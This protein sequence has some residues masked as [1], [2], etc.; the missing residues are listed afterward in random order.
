MWTPSNHFQQP[1]KHTHCM[2]ENS[3]PTNNNIP[4]S[5]TDQYPIHNTQALVSLLL[6]LISFLQSTQT[7]SH[8]N[9]ML[10]ND[11][12]P[13]QTGQHN[14][15][16]PIASAFFGLDNAIGI[17]NNDGLVISFNEPINSNSL[18]ASD[19]VIVDTNGNAH[20]PNIAT[21]APANDAGENQSVLLIGQ[22][23]NNAQAAPQQIHIVDDLTTQNQFNSTNLKGQ[24]STIIPLSAGP[25]LFSAQIVDPRLSEFE[26]TQNGQTLQVAWQG[27]ITPAS[28]IIAEEELNQFYTVY[29][30][31]NTGQ[32][33]AHTPS[34]IADINDNDNYHQ[35]YVNTTDP[36]VKVVVE[37]NSV[38]DPNNDPNPYTEIVL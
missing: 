7:S 10:S 23:G 20:T 19:F 24:S 25:E 3:T 33:I 4:Y 9:S 31:S 35:L 38:V 8:N 2:Q 14:N 29:T 32:L 21:L 36:I 27:G 18:Q 37:E 30:M 15:Q 17:Q 12:E 16:E 34:A 22:F 13:N 28:P 5:T 11:E 6:Q 1:Y 26:D